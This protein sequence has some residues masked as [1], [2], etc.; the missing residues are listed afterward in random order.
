MIVS[1][2]RRYLV[3]LL[4]RYSELPSLYIDGILVVSRTNAGEKNV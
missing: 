2:L 4:L 1:Q 3:Q